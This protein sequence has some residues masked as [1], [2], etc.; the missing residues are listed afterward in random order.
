MTLLDALTGVA[1]E[2]RGK[3]RAGTYH[4]LGRVAEEQRQWAAAE[5]YY[6]QALA[7]FVEFNDRYSQAGAYHQLGMVA[8]EQRQWAQAEEYYQQ[9][10][11]LYIEFNDKHGQ[12]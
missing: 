11:E 7:L 8:Q 2:W 6:R 1:D 10:L 5:G 9:A 3:D 4:Q 12:G